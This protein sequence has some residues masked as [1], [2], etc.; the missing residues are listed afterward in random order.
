MK[1]NKIKISKIKSNLKN[2][3]LIKDQKFKNLHC[4]LQETRDSKQNLG[5]PL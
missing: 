4:N 5:R 1:L 3:R 2:P